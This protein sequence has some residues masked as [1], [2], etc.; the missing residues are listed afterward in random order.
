MLEL[1]QQLIELLTL[2]DLRGWVNEKSFGHK[3]T[4]LEE[5]FIKVW[6]N[7][8]SVYMSDKIP[9]HKANRVYKILEEEL[10]LKE[11]CGFRD[12]RD[13]GYNAIFTTAEER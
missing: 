5:I 10:G 9:V 6:V 11:R 12:M 3:E 4:E 1:E 7:G 2:D 8:A 13:L